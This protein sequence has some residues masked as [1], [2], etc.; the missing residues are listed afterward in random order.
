MSLVLKK[1]RPASP[2]LGILSIIAALIYGASPIDLI[3][4]LL[5]LVGWVDDAAIGGLLMLFG[6]RILVRYYRAKR[7]RQLALK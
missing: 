6:V 7:A 4:D 5:V 3:P 1:D 2:A